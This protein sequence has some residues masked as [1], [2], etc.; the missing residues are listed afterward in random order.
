MSET[1]SLR[2]EL[3]L[4]DYEWLSEQAGDHLVSRETYAELLLSEGVQERRRLRNRV[5]QF[6]GNKPANRGD[7]GL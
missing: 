1:E 3:S 4:E 2:L 6:P 5:V 7:R